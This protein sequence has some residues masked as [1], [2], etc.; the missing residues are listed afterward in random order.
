[1]T[2]FF[3]TFPLAAWALAFYSS[4]GGAAVASALAIQDSS[5]R[6]FLNRAAAATTGAT[7]GWVL[8]QQHQ[9]GCMCGQCTNQHA[10]GCSCGM[11]TEQHGEG[12]QCGQCLQGHAAGCGCGQ[13]M[14][15]GLG[16]Q[17]AW[18]FEKREVGGADRS[19]DTAAFNIQSDKTYERLEKSGFPLDTKADEQA[20][21]SE[22]L[23]SFSYPD[24]KP[25]KGKKNEKTKK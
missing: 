12:C 10:D 9:A 14:R 23:S 3:F 1:M 25:S 15:L 2:K 21:L 19:A 17:G 16:P 7:M 8:T 24:S 20:R 4:F 6:A 22:D 13:C 5:R 11:C 18:A